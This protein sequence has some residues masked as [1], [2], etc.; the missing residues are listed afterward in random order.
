MEFETCSC[1]NSMASLPRK[2]TCKRSPSTC[3]VHLLLKWKKKFQSRFGTNRSLPV[4]MF[5]DQFVLSRQDMGRFI[6]RDIARINLNF[7]HYKPH[8]LRIGGACDLFQAGRSF[9]VIQ[10]L[11][12]WRYSCILIY[13]RLSMN[14]ILDALEEDF[15]RKI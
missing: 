8:S 15:T 11:G 14:K 6:K 5:D 13:L 4:F 10:I 7:D 1:A 12:R 9:N 2:C 3:P